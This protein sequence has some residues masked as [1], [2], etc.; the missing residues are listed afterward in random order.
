LKN[1][2]LHQNKIPLP[3]CGFGIRNPDRPRQ[4]AQVADGVVVG[5]SLVA[6]LEK[7]GS[8]VREGVKSKAAKRAIQ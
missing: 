7:E 3:V 8:G 2:P 1:S 5:T 6:L 4:M